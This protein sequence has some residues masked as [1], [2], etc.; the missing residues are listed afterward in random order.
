MGRTICKHA[1]GRL[2][3]PVGWA[4][5][6]LEQ[7]VAASE[8][9]VDVPATLSARIRLLSC[10]KAGKNDPNAALSAAV[11]GLRHTGLRVI[12]RED[13]PA[14]LRGAGRPPPRPHWLR[15]QAVCRLH[16][17]LCALAPGGLRRKLS[18]ARGR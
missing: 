18:A 16:A 11:A 2:K 10:G 3:E 9:V 17:L 14:V 4:T 12:A 15:T 8:L 6:W 13:H 7:L 1:R 5:C